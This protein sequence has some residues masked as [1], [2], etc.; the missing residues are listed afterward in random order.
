MMTDEFLNWLK[1]EKIESSKFE[2]MIWEM[3]WGLYQKYFWKKHKMW[4]S[5]YPYTDKFGGRISSFWNVI[6]F[7]SNFVTNSTKDAQN[8]IV[9]KAFELIKEL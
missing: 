5:I 4:L 2:K 6:H 1:S 8:R 3:K 9:E 7:D